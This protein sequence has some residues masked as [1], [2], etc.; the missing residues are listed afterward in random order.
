MPRADHQW[1]G[2]TA[3]GKVTL[4]RETAIKT[5]TDTA[6]YLPSTA[7][8]A[9]RFNAVTHAH[10]EVENA[11]HRRPDVAMNEDRNRTGMGHSPNNPATPRHMEIDIVRKDGSK[12]SLKGKSQRAGWDNDEP[13]RSFGLF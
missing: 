1:P 8:P 13:I 10:W 7:L 9:E 2:L 5:I 6:C 12:D 4:L 3:I 11:P